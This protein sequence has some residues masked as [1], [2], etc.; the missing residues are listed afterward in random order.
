MSRCRS[1]HAPILWARTERE[2]RIP[3]DPAP[4]TGPAAGGL[5]V[6]RDQASAEGPLA[7]AVTAAAYD[8][9][10]RYVSHFS[11]CPHADEHRRARGSARPTSSVGPDGGRAERCAK[12]CPN[13]PTPAGM[14]LEA[15]GQSAAT[16]HLLEPGARC[17]LDTGHDGRHRNGLLGW[18]DPPV[19][20]VG[21]ERIW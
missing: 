1:C 9:E 4:Y 5:F 2:R 18:Y 16:R 8:D 11:T 20:Y 15:V 19:L 14:T 17:E 10:P 12:R 13:P 21:E 3:L 7:V 6:L